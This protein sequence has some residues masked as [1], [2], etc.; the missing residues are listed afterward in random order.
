MTSTRRIAFAIYPGIQSLD[1]A[2]P[3]EV[4]HGAN[5]LR[6]RAGRQPSYALQVLAREREPVATESGLCVLPDRAL[7]RQRAAPDTLIVPGGSGVL[8]ALR[9]AALLRGVAR[10]TAGARRI[11]SVCSGAFLLAELG[12]LDGRK[13][14]THWSRCDQLARRYPALRVERE[15]IFL[16]DGHVY[17]S[18]GVTAGIDLA[19]AL[20][21]EDLGRGVALEIA[22]GLVM[23]LR[24]PGNQAQF[25]AQL[26]TQQ[27]DREPLRE[28]QRFIAEQPHA[29][30]GIEALAHRAL[31]SVRHFTRC[32]RAQVGVSPARYVES[33]RLEAARRRLVESQDGLERVAE[34]C[35]FGSA[36]VLR[37]AF[38]RRL[39]VTPSEYRTRFRSAH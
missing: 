2:G 29:D 34:S 20:V 19:L 23:F 17:T 6:A 10:L 22:R 15:P 38:V 3:F 33:A 26:R 35:G 30:L 4:F 12:L 18:A 11:V 24:R 7:A 8:D 27:A 21:E 28:V 32:F 16:R 14:T 39:N 5:T 31:M 9:D 37:R 1:L 13:V 36:E 25:S